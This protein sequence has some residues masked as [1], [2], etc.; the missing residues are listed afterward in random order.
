MRNEC[1]RCQPPNLSSKRDANWQIYETKRRLYFPRERS[2][3][4]AFVTRQLAE[5]S[6]KT[7]TQYNKINEVNF[8]LTRVFWFPNFSRLRCVTRLIRLYYEHNLFFW[9]TRIIKIRAFGE[10]RVY[11][12]FH[13]QHIIVM[14]TWEDTREIHAFIKSI[15]SFRCNCIKA[16]DIRPLFTLDFLLRQH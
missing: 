2:K 3:V 8:T 4:C 1:L 14:G 11:S 7:H 12:T 15:P 10:L 9:A 6:K 13:V 5:S 16:N